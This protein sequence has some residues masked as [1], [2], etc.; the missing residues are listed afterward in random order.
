VRAAIR[1]SVVVLFAVLLGPIVA[2]GVGIWQGLDAWAGATLTLW[3][4]LK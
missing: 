3:K 1:I 4:R 2:V